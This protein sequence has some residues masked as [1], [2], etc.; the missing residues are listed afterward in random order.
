MIL[1]LGVNLDSKIELKFLLRVKI[2]GRINNADQ[3]RIESF[4]I[5]VTVSSSY[6]TIKTIA[7]LTFKPIN[8]HCILIIYYNQND[9]HEKIIK[10][11]LSKRSISN[12]TTN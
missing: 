1:N 10:K 9:K 2:V 6:L 7:S 12:K 5:F 11:K 3:Y 4:T 8:S